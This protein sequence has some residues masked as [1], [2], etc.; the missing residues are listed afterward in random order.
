MPE[1][2]YTALSTRANRSPLTGRRRPRPSLLLGGRPVLLTDPGYA[3]QSFLISQIPNP[4]GAC[5]GQVSFA[6]LNEYTLRASGHNTLL[7]MAGQVVAA[8]VTRGTDWPAVAL[9]AA[10]PP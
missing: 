6:H 8:K 7:S 3:V 1:G 9:N 4:G 5:E 2:K 10:A